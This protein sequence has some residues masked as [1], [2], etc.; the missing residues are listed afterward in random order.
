MSK[1]LP[2]S[3]VAALAALTSFGAIRAVTPQP[4]DA[5]WTKSWWMPRHLA[6]LAAATN[7]HDLR[8]QGD[9]PCDRRKAAN[10]PHDPHSDL[11]ARRGYRIWWE[12][13]QPVV[14][15]ITGK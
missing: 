9:S 5:E 13:L 1:V 15:E 7:G 12:N 4:A 2:L 8:H 14:K 6:K 10:R 3:F 11:S